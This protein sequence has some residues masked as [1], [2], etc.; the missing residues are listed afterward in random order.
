MASG[1]RFIGVVT[2]SGTV[3]SDERVNKVRLM[4]LCRVLDVDENNDEPC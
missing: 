4:R 3:V 1:V 2:V